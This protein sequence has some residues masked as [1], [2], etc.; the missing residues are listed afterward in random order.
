[1]NKYAKIGARIAAMRRAKGAREGRKIGQKEMAEA[2]GVT[3]STATAWE[4]GKQRPMD[5]NLVRLATFLGC[6]PDDIVPPSNVP[7]A[8]DA[9]PDE[10][11]AIMRDRALD[12]IARVWMVEAYA[13]A[14]RAR[15]MERAEEAALERARAMTSDARSAGVRA[16]VAGDAPRPPDTDA[17]TPAQPPG[18]TTRRRGSGSA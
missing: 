7:A 12:E 2:S 8:P 14:R 17:T 13:A 9:A 10:L 16:G 6:S 1:M 11:E 5:D 4:T 15:A 18:Q 3:H